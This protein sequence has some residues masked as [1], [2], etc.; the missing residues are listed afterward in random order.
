MRVKGRRT[1]KTTGPGWCSMKYQA[2]VGGK[3]PRES[4]GNNDECE[5]GLFLSLGLGIYMTFR[6]RTAMATTPRVSPKMKQAKVGYESRT[7]SAQEGSSTTVRR[8]TVSVDKY[9]VPST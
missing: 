7:M 6:T 9:P 5:T 1:N 8:V 4:Q 3:T 2:K